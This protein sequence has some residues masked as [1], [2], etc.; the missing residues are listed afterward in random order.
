MQY[1]YVYKITNI[2]PVDITKYY[3]G[4]RTSDID[5]LDDTTYFGS[6]TYLKKAIKSQGKINFLKEILSVWETREKANIEEIRL[7]QLYEVSTN[8]EFYNKSKSRSS[9]FCVKGM[10]SVINISTQEV[11]FVTI[12][13]SKNKDKYQSL[14]QNVV[15]ATDKITGNKVKVTKEEYKDN[16]NLE[17][18]VKGTITAID[19][20]TGLRQQVTIDEFNNNPNLVGQMKGR[21]NVL[22]TRTGIRKSVLKEEYDSND[23]YVSVSAG[24]LTV[25]DIRDG[26]TKKISTA[27]YQQN[28]N[29]YV[30]NNTKVVKIYDSNDSL[31]YT[32]YNKFKVFCRQHGLPF[33][34]FSE[35][36]QQD[37]KPIYSI[38]G[39]NRSRLEK[40]GY[41]KYIGWYAIDQ[42][43]L[44]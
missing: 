25:I 7:H 22:D 34:A 37:G 15:N 35:S 5:P 13:E 4:V 23:Y 17:H 16:P 14:Y 30:T 8:P 24:T 31:V 20:E 41:L 38:I 6:S 19:I 28:T 33:N 29:S 10:T 26:L 32:C 2:N 36:K 42:N 21:V 9:K 11:E 18:T 39:S 44:I 27:E 12:E 40:S 1:H 43:G 3:I